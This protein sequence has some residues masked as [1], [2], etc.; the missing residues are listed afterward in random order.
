M[1]LYNKYY[2][3]KIK[4]SK[5]QKTA[6]KTKYGLYKYQ[7]IPFKLIN[8]LI[9]FIKLINNILLSYLNIYYIYYLN[10]ILV[11]LNNKSQYIKNVNNIFENLVKADL[12]YKPNKYKFYIK[13][14]EFLR[15]IVLNQKFKINKD[16][17]KAML[18]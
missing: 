9:T 12:L 15:F 10:N 5:K 16:K 8:T 7:V 17:I 6:F 2:L 14:T 11:Y 1:N 13:K 3:I 18:K 4:K